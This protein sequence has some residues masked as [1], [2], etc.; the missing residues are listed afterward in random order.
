MRTKKRRRTLRFAGYVAVDK[1]TLRFSDG[2]I[3]RRVWISAC[4]LY[5]IEEARGIEDV[6]FRTRSGEQE[7]HWFVHQRLVGGTIW[8]LV[9]RGRDQKWWRTWQAADAAIKRLRSGS[10]SGAG[11]AARDRMSRHGMP[12]DGTVRRRGAVTPVRD[13]ARM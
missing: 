3:M 5:R 12:A 6:R 13:D 4:G 2:S 9:P 7:T 11:M 8:Q 1:L 10:L